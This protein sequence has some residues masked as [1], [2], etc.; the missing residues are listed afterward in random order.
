MAHISKSLMSQMRA[1]EVN[2]FIREAQMLA[3]LRHPNVCT[4]YGIGVRENTL[5]LIQELCDSG[6]LRDFVSK[7]GAFTVEAHAVTFTRQLFSTMAYL[8]LRVPPVIHR[9]IK[10]DNLLIS[11]GSV[12]KIG[13]LGT[14]REQGAAIEMMTGNVT[15]TVHYMPPEAL[16]HVY[17]KRDEAPKKMDGKKWDV[18]SC[19][20]CVYFMYLDGVDPFSEY[21]GMTVVRKVKDED[22]R[23]DI[24]IVGLTLPAAIAALVQKMWAP[25]PTARPTMRRALDFYNAA[26]KSSSAVISIDAKTSIK[27]T[28]DT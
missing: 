21:T 8:H 20:M 4:F 9:D 12:L 19:G 5:Y 10:P 15:G 17:R 11:G 25:D 7:K 1:E 3:K 14:S 18:Y 23:P 28:N 16:R 27:T 24:P 2:E 13:D 26:L 6:S 22:A